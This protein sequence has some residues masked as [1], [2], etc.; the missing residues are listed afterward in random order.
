MTNQYY[1]D[2]AYD[3][4]RPPVLAPGDNSR[5]GK[6][7]RK[8]REEPLNTRGMHCR[9]YLAD[10]DAEVIE[11]L[12]DDCAE[13][14]KQLDAPGHE[15]QPWQTLSN[16]RAVVAVISG[17]SGFFSFGSIIGFFILGLKVGLLNFVTNLN[18]IVFLIFPVIYLLG[19][20]LLRFDLVKDKNNVLLNRRT[21]MITIPQKKAAPLELPFDEFDPYLTTGTNPTGSS[22]FYLQLGHRYSEA[23]VQYPP[24]M[25]E[26]WQVY[27]AWEYWQQYMDISKPLPDTP[28]MEPYRSRDP[29]SAEFDR[30]QKR[31]TDYWKSMDIDQAREMKKA[32][33]KAATR[34]PWGASREQALAQGWRP[35]GYGEGPSTKMPPSM[36]KMPL[37]QQKETSPEDYAV[38]E[39]RGD[40][41]GP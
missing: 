35:S 18:I 11:L 1:A 37:K 10:D 4:T 7:T 23:R 38:V 15:S 16:P 27:Q 17:V 12:N 2:T 41:E 20:L 24:N 29:V 5:F 14:R 33:V 30:Q 25:P 39:K 40:F 34:Y 3:N 28:R 22:D 8:L 36:A 26:P 21:G 31:P 13:V 6:I 32:S 9:E 19:K